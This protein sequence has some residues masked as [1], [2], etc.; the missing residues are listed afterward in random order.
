YAS[1]GPCIGANSYEVGSEFARRFI[2]KSLKFETFFKPAL[3]SGHHFFDLSGYVEMRLA[4][5]G[6]RA[7]D[8]C[9]EDTYPDAERFFSFRRS[10]H[11]GE[12]DYGR[13]LS[14]VV[15]R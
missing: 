3:R 7:I 14:A 13:T 4:A 1:I 2:K 5:C 8:R 11:S 10:Q 15:L 9:N 12:V 6:V